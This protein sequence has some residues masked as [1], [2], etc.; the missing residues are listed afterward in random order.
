MADVTV[1]QIDELESYDKIEKYRGQFVYAGK[2]LGVTAWGMNILR[3]PPNWAEYPEH[4][5]AEDGQEEV[6]VV[7]QGSA[8]LQ[9]E[10]KSWPLDPGNLARVGP[11]V[12]RKIIPGS[13]G[14]MLLAI[15]GTPHK[16]YKL[17]S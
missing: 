17:P 16:A 1:K 13:K 15:G 6:Y 3:L 5:H 2:G 7:L 10:G 4:D 12:T 8:T 9:A 14:V 11:R